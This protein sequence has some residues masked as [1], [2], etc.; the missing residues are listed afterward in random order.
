M[1]DLIEKVRKY[2]TDKPEFRQQNKNYLRYEMKTLSQEDLI[3]ELKSMNLEELRYAQGA[4][5]PG[6]ANLICM[7]LIARR[8]KEYNNFMKEQSKR[9]I[10]EVEA[11]KELSLTTQ[12][13][14]EEKD[15]WEEPGEDAEETSESVE[16]SFSAF[17]A[18]RE[19]DR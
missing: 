4:G 14:T 15:K 1:G 3:D 8:Q 17:E 5:V 12:V 9:K 18:G 6:H 11:E 7:Q 2:M 19:G 16:D 13:S 10:D